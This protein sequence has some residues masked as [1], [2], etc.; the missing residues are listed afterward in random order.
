MRII[1]GRHRGRNISLGKA[2][3]IRPT[4]DFTRQAVFNILMHGEYGGVEGKVVADIC[5][6][7]GAFGLEALSRGAAHAVFVDASQESLNVAKEN[8]ATFREEGNATFIR[9]DAAQLP[10]AKMQADLLF[11]DPP[12]FSGLLPK[13]LSGLK[14]QAWLKPDTLVIVE[15]D[16]TENFT[17][18]AGFEERDVR[19]YGRACVRFL[20]ARA[21]P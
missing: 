3:H 5:C 10:P 9:A 12:Y 16:G 15:H 20:T 21:Q 6:G 19:N 11:L 1:S 4:S 8:V 17:L 7:S 13:A 18:P 14:S 2:G